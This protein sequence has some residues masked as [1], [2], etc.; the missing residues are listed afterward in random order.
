MKYKQNIY[1][2]YFMYANVSKRIWNIIF[3]ITLIKQQQN[4][5]YP[6]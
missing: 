1:R 4:H 3:K 6:S 5:V 2:M